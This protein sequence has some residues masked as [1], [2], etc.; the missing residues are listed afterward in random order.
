MQISSFVADP[1]C[2]LRLSQ[3][4]MSPILSHSN[5]MPLALGILSSFLYNHQLILIVPTY[6]LQFRPCST[7]STT[8]VILLLQMFISHVLA[9]SC[10]QQLTSRLTLTQDAPFHLLCSTPKAGVPALTPI[11]SLA[12]QKSLPIFKS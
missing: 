11:N 5:I 1:L 9:H 2:I 7:L 12:S 3:R 10:V 8:P 4:T 6:S